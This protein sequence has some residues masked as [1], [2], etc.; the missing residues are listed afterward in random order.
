MGTVLI[1]VGVPLILCLM[2]AA[3]GLPTISTTTPETQKIDLGSNATTRISPTDSSTATEITTQSV[4]TTTAISDG[5]GQCQSAWQKFLI[6]FNVHYENDL[7]RQKRN[8]IFCKNWKNVQNHNSQYE[9]GLESFRKG[10]NQWSDLTIEEWK[11]KQRPQLKPK[12]SETDLTIE[13]GE[14]VR[15]NKNCQAAWDKFLIEFGAKYYDAAE[16]ERRKDIFCDNWK[17]IQVHNL[18]YELGVESFKKGINQWSDLTI[19]EWKNKQRPSLAPEFSKIQFSTETSKNDQDNTKCQD[20]WEKFLIDFGAK[21]EDAAEGEKRQ[22]IFCD[23]WKAIQK[24]NVQYDLWVESFK[25]GINQW[26][27]LTIAESKNKQQ[28]SL[29]PEFSRERTKSG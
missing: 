26:S 25:K 9:S 8:I 18:Q 6:D 28:P 10:I 2:G 4:K 29:A 20:A 17:A 12:I 13:A 5:N 27:D 22:Q 21:Y 16:T 11:E 24:H 3:C 7:E 19:E 1:I 23:N 14:D 15:D